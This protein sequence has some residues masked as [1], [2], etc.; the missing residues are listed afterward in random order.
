MF[1][2][3]R[4]CTDHSGCM[5][6]RHRTMTRAMPDAGKP[7]PITL[8]RSLFTKIKIKAYSFTSKFKHPEEAKM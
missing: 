5:C 6:F 8:S 4:D 3:T 1:N 7:K 2:K